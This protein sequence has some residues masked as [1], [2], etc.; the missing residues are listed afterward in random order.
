MRGLYDLKSRTRKELR[1]YL[2]EIREAEKLGYKD[3]VDQ[4]WNN[5]REERQQLIDL[6]LGS[7]IE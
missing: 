5:Y 3:V 7:K 2:A 4:L 1:A 6:L